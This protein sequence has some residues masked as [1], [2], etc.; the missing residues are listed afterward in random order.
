MKHAIQH[1]LLF[2]EILWARPQNVHKR[3]LGKVLIVA[4][5]KT[6]SGA[7][8]MCAEAAFRTGAGLVVMAY[9]EGLKNVYRAVLPEAMSVIVPETS[10]GT[11]A[12]AGVEE[13]LKAA[14]TCDVVVV[15]PGLSRHPETA[16]LVRQ[17]VWRLEK[18][19]VLDADGLNAIAD[20]ERG[21]EAF[22]A[23]RQ[24]PTVL[25]PHI[26]EMARLTKRSSVAVAA[27][28]AH[29]AGEA[30]RTWKSIVVL[31]GHQTLIAASDGPPGGRGSPAGGRLVENRSGSPALATAG[32]GDVLAGM[33]GT[34]VAQNTGKMFEATVTAVYLHGRAG[35]IAERIVGTRSVTASDVMKALP[36]AI[37]N[38]EREM[39]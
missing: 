1:H 38:I 24:A 28:R 25:T 22:F 31:K 15:G 17:L 8:L 32:T 33:V 3:Q 23:V 29:V 36:E 10:A 2:P 12:R 5:S 21:S 4:G 34:L 7:G 20:D 9:P 11:M 13:V 14:E 37:K 30:A 19:L 26:G 27:D 39:V 6:M 18:P 35:E 16:Q